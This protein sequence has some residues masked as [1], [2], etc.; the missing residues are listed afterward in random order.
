[1]S[2]REA[3][4]IKR[5]FGVSFHKHLV[6]LRASKHSLQK[7]IQSASQRDEATIKHRPGATL[8]T[9][10]VSF[11]WMNYLTRWLLCLERV[12]RLLLSRTSSSNALTCS[13]ISSYPLRLS[14]LH[15]KTERGLNPGLLL[16]QLV[17]ELGSLRSRGKAHIAAQTLLAAM[18]RSLDV[19][20]A[21]TRCVTAHKLAIDVFAV[22]INE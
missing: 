12:F 20:I 13:L 14:C 8:L 22:A 16:H 2:R 10:T 9:S 3:E 6:A 19:C 4:V 7:P 17:V 15:L 1:M 5:E 11:L 18:I 21:S